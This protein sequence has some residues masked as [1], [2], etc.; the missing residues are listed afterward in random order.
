MELVIGDAVE[1]YNPSHDICRLMINAAVEIL[2]KREH[3]IDNFDFLLSGKLDDFFAQFSEQMI[4]L[5]LN[6]D[7]LAR[8]LATHSKQHFDR[9]FF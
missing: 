7:A 2:L 1:G 4:C 8:K 5:L 6:D 3:K 9:H